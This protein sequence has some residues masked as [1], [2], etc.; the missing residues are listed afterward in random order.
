MQTWACCFPNFDRIQAAKQS[1]RARF[2]SLH[3][4]QNT[5]LCQ[6]DTDKHP[7]LTMV[8]SR[9]Q[10]QLLATSYQLRPWRNSYHIVT[11]RKKHPVLTIPCTVSSMFEVNRI[12]STD[13]IDLFYSYVLRYHIFEVFR[14]TLEYKSKKSMSLD[15]R[16]RK[17]T[18]IL[19]REQTE[20]HTQASLHVSMAKALRMKGHMKTTTQQPPDM[21]YD[22]KNPQS[23]WLITHDSLCVIAWYV[24]STFDWR[25]A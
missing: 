7:I 23:K 17:H 24:K 18:N 25:I 14:D 21:K 11:N 5:E 22:T 4:E 19:W 1:P 9:S 8:L 10:A 2:L 6:C 15:S 13:F 12:K 16:E 3:S 20:T